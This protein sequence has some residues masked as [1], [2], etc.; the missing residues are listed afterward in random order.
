[1]SQ[2]TLGSAKSP[3]KVR[4]P[5]LVLLFTILTLGIYAIYYYYCTFEELKNWR[6]QGWSGGTY[7][8]FALVPLVNVVS[9]AVPWL[10]PA[11]IGRMFAE[12]GQAKPITGLSGCWIFLPLIGAI[13][14]LVSVQNN[15]NKFWISKKATA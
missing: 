13:I 8:I 15:L 12:D 7:L 9:I 4:N 6:G 10:L 2:A 14:L 5:W 1:M 3:G 11:Y